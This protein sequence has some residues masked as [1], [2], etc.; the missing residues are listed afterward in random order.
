MGGKK[1]TWRDYLSWGLLML[2]VFVL[3]WTTVIDHSPGNTEQAARRVEKVLARRMARLDTY[4]RQA[5]DGNWN[6]SWTSSRLTWSYTAMSTM[7][8][9]PGT[10]PS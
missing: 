8:S 5:L 1:H 9:S 3:V 4:M 7:S 2:S 6:W 10:I